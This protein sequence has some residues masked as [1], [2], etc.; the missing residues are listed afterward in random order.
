MFGISKVMIFIAI[1]ISSLL[2]WATSNVCRYNFT[3]EKKTKQLNIIAQELK[4]SLPLAEIYYFKELNCNSVNL[5]WD[6]DRVLRN[7]NTISVMIYQELTTDI[8]GNPN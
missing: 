1:I 5:G 6:V 7:L 8:R 4:P 3:I 2:Y